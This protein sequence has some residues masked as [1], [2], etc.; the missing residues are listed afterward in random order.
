MGVPAR[1]RLRCPSAS[2]TCLASFP[3]LRPSTFHF[4]LALTRREKTAPGTNGSRANP[5]FRCEFA[6]PGLHRRIMRFFLLTTVLTVG[7]MTGSANDARAYTVGGSGMDSCGAW[8]A[9][10]GAFQPDR[11]VNREYLNKLQ[12]E[13]WVLGFLSGLGFR[14]CP[15]SFH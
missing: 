8:T 14:V 7:L 5:Q 10:R 11:P 2:G 13:Q 9:H 15:R 4:S 12:A 3:G 1:T 6:T